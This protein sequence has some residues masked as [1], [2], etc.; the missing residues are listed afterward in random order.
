MNLK[1]M[2]S[3]QN[4]ADSKS[5]LQSALPLD[6]GLVLLITF[7]SIVFV[8]VPPYN[9]TPIRIPFAL[10]LLLFIPGYSFV[11][12]L[13]PR[14]DDLTGIER[15][16]LSI[17]LSIA[18]VIFDGFALHY[19]SWGFRP[20]PI[21]L[22]LSAITLLLVLITLVL[23]IKIPVNER[24]LFDY[25]AFLKSLKAE[26][27]STTLEKALVVALVASIVIASGIVIYGKRTIP[28]ETFTAFY[29]LDTNGKAENYVTDL[30]LGRQASVTVGIENHEHSPVNYILEAKLGSSTV[31]SQEITLGHGENWLGDVSFIVNRVG[32]RV[33]LEFLLYKDG[34]TDP[35]RSLHLWVVSHIDYENPE[36]LKKYTLAHPPEIKNGDMKFE[37]GS[38]WNYINNNRYFKGVFFNPSSAVPPENSMIKGHI[39]DTVTGLPIAKAS[40]EISNHYGYEN[41]TLSSKSGYYELKTI[42]DHLWLEAWSSGYQQ[43]STEFAVADGQILVLNIT[44]ERLPLNTVAF[45]RLPTGELQLPS[46]GLNVETLPP[47]KQSSPNPTLKGYVTDEVTDFPVANAQVRAT[48]YHGFEDYATTNERGYFEMRAI[49]EYLEIGAQ[50]DGYMRNVT[51]INVLKERTTELKLTPKHSTVNGYISD[52]VGEPVANA[53]IRVGDHIEHDKQSYYDVAVSNEMGYYEIRTIAGHLWLDASKIDYF[54]NCMEF[55][56]AYGATK[57]IDLRLASMP[58]E[59]A[60][61]SGYVLHNDIR[62]VL[63]GVKIVVSDHNYYER[64]TFTD[65]NG[66]YE[67]YT[68]PGHLWLDVDPEIYSKSIELDVIDGQSLSVNIALDA[69]PMD[70]YEIYYPSN[71]R[72]EYGYY[73]A[74]YQDIVSEGGIAVLSLKVKDSYTKSKSNGYHFKQVLLNDVVLWED[75]VAGDEGWQHVQIPIT[76]DSGVN[77]IT[78]RVYEKQAVGGFSVHVWWDDVRIEPM[79]TLITMNSAVY[80]QI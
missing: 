3:F 41:R 7:L 29:L 22:S 75:D 67:I 76:L 73:G 66:Y 4:R 14:K 9:R 79:T 71:T 55:D 15:L 6:L 33:K 30:Y 5:K 50:A 25:H 57:Q 31:N 52:E 70:T 35:Y 21:V 37:L 77:R 39:I 78:L 59:N 53:N 10:P 62:T 44:L 28:E 11:S 45:E 68:V 80:P 63:G 65:G 34:S 38:N 47:D 54:A 51:A 64:S 8:L 2:K 46:E 32:P 36:I 40:I 26:E 23:R 43:H 18:L 58:A 12:L 60:K 16:T 24:Y 19:T 49:P 20:A 69:S 61:I 74:I 42:A 17:V 27:K 56:I 72:S 1:Y 13:F 48:N